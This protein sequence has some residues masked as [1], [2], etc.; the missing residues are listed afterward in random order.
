MGVGEILDRGL[1][2]YLANLGRLLP[3]ALVLLVPLALLGI[4]TAEAKA[5]SPENPE[6]FLSRTMAGYLVTTILGILGGAVLQGALIQ[7]VSDLVLG[8]PTG[9][10]TAF[11]KAFDRLL[12]MIGAAILVTIAVMVGLLL[13]IVP[14]VVAMA[15]LSFVNA[16]VMLERKSVI[17]SCRRSWALA[18]G[19]RNKVLLLVGL[20]GV[21]S[22]L[23]G[24]IVSGF[25]RW[26]HAGPAVLTALAQAG[27][28]FFAPFASIV[29]IL[30]YYDLRVR[31][32]A[33][34]LEVL[35]REMGRPSP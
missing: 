5:P 14:G 1:R 13:F 7:A 27:N 11:G 35:A 12:P 24:M 8:R 18:R 19:F 15:G 31:K 17:E 22:L 34:D 23:W 3:I 2:I 30:L 21:L 28:V 16:A 29:T 20:A 32:E 9:V 26:A 6:N 33:F 25:V 4:A 10:R